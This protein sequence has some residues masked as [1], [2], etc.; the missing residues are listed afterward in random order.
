MAVRAT[1]KEKEMN[2]LDAAMMGLLFVGWATVAI[3]ILEGLTFAMLQNRRL[4]RWVDR[5]ARGCSR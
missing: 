4:S 2:A 3:I 1:T 5:C